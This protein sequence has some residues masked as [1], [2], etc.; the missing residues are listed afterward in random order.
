MAAPLLITLL[1]NSSV[2]NHVWNNEEFKNSSFQYPLTT[3]TEGEFSSTTF[4]TL[5]KFTKQIPL[6]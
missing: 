4:Q 5:V 2:T 3:N 1:L 6:D